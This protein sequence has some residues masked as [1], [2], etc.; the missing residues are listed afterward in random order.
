V[1]PTAI[2][3]S[4][5]SYVA[6]YIG[7]PLALDEND[8]DTPLPS[9]DPVDEGIWGI[10]ESDYGHAFKNRFGFEKP[11]YPVSGRV[12]A[13]FRERARLGDFDGFKC[14]VVRLICHQQRL[15]MVQSWKT[16]TL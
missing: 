3:P 12:I 13:T 2:L 16:S 4:H 5:D 6:T 9:D 1:A 11:P 10:S 7:R 14:P 8:Y 15:F